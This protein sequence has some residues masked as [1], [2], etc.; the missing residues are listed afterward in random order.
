MFI[1]ING[2]D[3]T[4]NY[5]SVI[6]TE[7]INN[8][9]FIENAWSIIVKGVDYKGETLYTRIIITQEEYDRLKLILDI[10]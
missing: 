8:F 9:I 7:N 6:K 3:N 4:V 2:I 5:I 1:E 10:K